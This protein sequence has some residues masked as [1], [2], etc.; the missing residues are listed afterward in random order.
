MLSSEKN[1][2]LLVRKVT[3]ENGKFLAVMVTW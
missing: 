3:L 1:T 2:V